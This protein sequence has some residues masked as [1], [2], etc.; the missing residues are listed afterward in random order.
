MVPP[1]ESD[2]DT[3]CGILN[4]QKSKILLQLAVNAEYDYNTTKAIFE[5]QWR[6]RLEVYRD[7]EMDHRYR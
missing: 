1:F 2:A 3:V 5:F 6:L 4:P 7:D